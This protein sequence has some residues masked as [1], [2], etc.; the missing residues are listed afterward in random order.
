[1][2]KLTDELIKELAELKKENTALKNQCE[3]LQELESHLEQIVG[4][5][6]AKLLRAEMTSLELEQVFSACTDALWVICENGT[7]IRAN[8]A[9]LDLLNKPL[10]NVIGHKCSELL[11][12]QHCHTDSCPIINSIEHKQELDI[13]LPNSR[14]EQFHYILS[15]APLITLDGGH[16]IVGQFKDITS[17]KLAEDKLAAANASLKRLAR[18][19]GLTQIG[20]R[21]YFDETL[22][23][24]W[25]RLRRERKPLSLLLGDIDFF[26]KFNDHYGHQAGDDCLRLIGQILAGSI[27]RPADLAARYGGEEFAL[28]LPET[29]MEGALSV[30]E[31]TL[32]AIRKLGISHA[33]STVNDVVTMSMGVVTLIPS[34]EQE[35]A[36]LIGLA[37]EALYQA[38]EQGRNRVVQ[39]ATPLQTASAVD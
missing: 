32:E 12:Y 24:E 8:E 23:K 1:M 17:R 9:M 10:D 22:E 18:I 4:D 14:N 7:V 6:N 33:E 29:D 34:N 5:D 16:G 35:P 36:T 31:R 25:L 30:G 19:D 27:L 20:N 38:K 11:D 3:E 2:S 39:A 26:K 13:Q 15:T 21:R 37:D 28:V